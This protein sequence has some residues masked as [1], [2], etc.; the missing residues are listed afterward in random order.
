[1]IAASILLLARTMYVSKED[2]SERLLRGVHPGINIGNFN[3]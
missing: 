2:S 1:V 3:F